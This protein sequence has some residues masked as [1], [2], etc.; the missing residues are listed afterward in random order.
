MLNLRWLGLPSRLAEPNLGPTMQFKFD[1][2]QS[3]NRESYRCLV[4]AGV[5]HESESSLSLF[6]PDDRLQ[7]VNRYNNGSSHRTA[8]GG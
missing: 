3:L 4:S 5:H 2:A 7:G 8:T 6:S 1:F